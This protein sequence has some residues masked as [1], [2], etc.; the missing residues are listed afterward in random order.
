MDKTYFGIIIQGRNLLLLE[1]IKKLPF[2]EFWEESSIG[3]AQ[4]IDGSG[5]VLIYL[6][7]WERFAREF[8]K[9]GRHRYQK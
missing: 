4:L 7:D 1:D 5:R 8:I 3:S 2:Y 9:T 6:H